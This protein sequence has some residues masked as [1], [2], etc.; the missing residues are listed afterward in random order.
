MD[1][2]YQYKDTILIYNK[3]LTS[4]RKEEVQLRVF[5]KLKE[6][7]INKDGMN[8]SFQIKK[9]VNLVTLISDRKNMLLSTYKYSYPVGLSMFN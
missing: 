5:K 3:L 6:K 7:L 4:Y 2:I 8:A 9:L 1:T